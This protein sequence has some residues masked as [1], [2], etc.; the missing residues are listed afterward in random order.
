MCLNDE[1][2]CVL[3]VCMC[4]RC[5]TGCIFN[6]YR[7]ITGCITSVLQGV[8]IIIIYTYFKKKLKT[9][10]PICDRSIPVTDPSQISDRYPSQI[11]RRSAADLRPID[12]VA[13]QQPISMVAYRSLICDR[14]FRWLIGRYCATELRPND[15]GR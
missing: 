12:T 11:G 10:R 6:Y 9:Q 5:I 15:V 13:N 14:F 1:C 8:Y 3:Q 4:Y 2:C 7:C